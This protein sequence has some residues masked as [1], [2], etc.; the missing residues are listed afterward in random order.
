MKESFKYK[1]Q[2]TTLWMVLL[3][4]IAVNAHIL[5]LAFQEERRQEE[6]RQL[7]LRDDLNLD[8]HI[9]KVLAEELRKKAEHDARQP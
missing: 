4:T 8:E 7:R 1:L 6:D 9:R 2:G 3:T 5:S